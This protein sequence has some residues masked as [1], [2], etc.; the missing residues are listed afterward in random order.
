MA[1]VLG[2]TLRIQATQMTIVWTRR[3]VRH[4]AALR[5]F[6]ARDSS[7]HAER[8]AMQILEAVEL[9]AGKPSI[10]RPGRLTGTRDLVVAGT[11]YGVPYRIRNGRLELIA[12]F[13][14]RQK[15]PSKL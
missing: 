4:L 3:A 9:L 8:V 13:H 6:I 2:Q 10:G 5:A 14:G 15:W 1:Q 7:R 11:P 12:V